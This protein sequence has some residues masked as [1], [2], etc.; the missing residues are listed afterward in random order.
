M[1]AGGVQTSI[2]IHSAVLQFTEHEL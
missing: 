1:F 2:D